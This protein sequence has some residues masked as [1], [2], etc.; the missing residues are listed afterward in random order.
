MSVSSIDHIYVGTKAEVLTYA[1][2]YRVSSGGSDQTHR[3]IITGKDLAQLKLRLP[4]LV[5]SNAFLGVF[6]R[7]L[8][9]IYDSGL[10]RRWEEVNSANLL[11]AVNSSTEKLS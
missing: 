10:W 2:A 1:T 6:S 5:L 4:F 11:K 8:Y 3:Q 9:Q 7:K